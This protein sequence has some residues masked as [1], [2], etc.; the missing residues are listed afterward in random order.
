MRKNFVLIY[1]LLDDIVDY[2]YPQNSS[3]E[4]LKEYVLN[5]PTL[6]RPVSS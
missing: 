2:G 3:S 1:E 6:I 4:A 5:E